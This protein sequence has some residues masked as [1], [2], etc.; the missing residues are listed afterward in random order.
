MSE[1]ETSPQTSGRR[2]HITC[3]V[4]ALLGGG[5]ALLSE[6]HSLGE[7]LGVLLLIGALSAWGWY[8]GPWRTFA[9]AGK[10]G[11][12][13]VVPFFNGMALLQIAQK[14]GW[15]MPLWLVPGAQLIVGFLVLSALSRRFGRSVILPALL[16]FAAAAPFYVA[17][18]TWLHVGL[19]ELQMYGHFDVVLGL[20]IKAF[21]AGV[22]VSILAGCLPLGLGRIRPPDEG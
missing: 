22:H 10:P 14:P 20:G 1:T 2:V 15:W 17:S 11:W 21:I 7:F 3:C 4:L 19:Y 9:R 13:S 8:S 12:V 18:I 16:F 6:S 5:G